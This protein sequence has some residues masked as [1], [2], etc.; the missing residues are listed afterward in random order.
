M[1]GGTWANVQG[2]TSDESGNLYVSVQSD[3]DA[4]RGYI[5]RLARR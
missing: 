3:L 5:L 1:F 2:I 4:D